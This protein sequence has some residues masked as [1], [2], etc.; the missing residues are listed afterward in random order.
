MMRKS[1]LMAPAEASLRN[2]RALTALGLVVALTPA[3]PVMAN[4]A[5]SPE[6]RATA[7]VAQM[8]LEEKASQ[9]VN[10][11]PA[12]ARL[13]LPDYQWWS[14]ALHGYAFHPRATNY[15]EPIGRG[16]TFNAPL[17]KQVAEAISA[18]GIAASDAM[19]ASG[20][21]L[22]LGAGRTFWSPNINIFRDPRWGR[23]QE[24]YG[25]DPFLTS[26]MGV[27]YVTGQTP[28]RRGSLRHRSILRFTA[29]PNRRATAPM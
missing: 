9:M 24:T 4:P 5:P 3:S 25:E 19:V 6:Q 22:D 16:A 20:R 13:N 23:G 21:P 2:M 8:T 28:M 15:P 29:V 26:R 14:E 7:I 27:A 17:V 10:S 11:A 1:D 12:I 18:E